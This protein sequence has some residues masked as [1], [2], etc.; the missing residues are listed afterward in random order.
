MICDER[1]QGQKNSRVKKA[2]ESL[3]I[4]QEMEGSMLLGIVRVSE[5]SHKIGAFVTELTGVKNENGT[6]YFLNG[7]VHVHFAG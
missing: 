2:C 7:A 6:K 4:I 5:A 1:G 3:L